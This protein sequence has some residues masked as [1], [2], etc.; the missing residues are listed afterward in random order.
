[1]S[2]SIRGERRQKSAA[3]GAAAIEAEIERIQTLNTAEARSLWQEIF[4]RPVALTDT[5]TRDD[6]V[7]ASE[8]HVLGK[9]VLAGRFHR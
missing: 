1:M 2:R 7:K 4:K 5:A 3:P 9:A 8:G 6:V